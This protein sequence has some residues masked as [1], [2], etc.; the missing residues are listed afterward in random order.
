MNDLPKAAV[1]SCLGGA[2]GDLGV[3]R[4]LGREGVPVTVVAESRQAIALRSR[5][6]RHAVV[7]DTFTT[8]HGRALNSLVAYARQEKHKPVL[9]PTADPDLAFVSNAR[10]ELAKYYHLFVSEKHIID[11]F[12]DKRRFSRLAEK[13]DFPVPR[14][15]I[16]KT[17]GDVSRISEEMEYPA[18][19]KPA[20]SSSWSNR[21]I[22]DIVNDKKAVTVDSPREL[23]DIY[24]RIA[25]YNT[26][27]LIQEYIHGRDDTLYS[28][29]IYFDKKSQPVAYFT[30]RK[31]RTYPAYAGIGC[32]VRSIFVQEIV[33]KGIEMLKRVQYTG[34]ALLQFK[35]DARSNEFR[36][37]EINPR[38]S[39]WNLLAYHCG[40]NLPFLAYADAAG[41]PFNR[42]GT[43]TDNVKYVFFGN[44]I[45]AF[46]EYR[47]HGEWTT[48]SWLKSFRG[49]KVFQLYARDDFGPFFVSC[50]RFV[51]RV[52][53]RIIPR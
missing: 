23:I 9:F 30:G 19:I 41:V 18:I 21:A 13:Y 24:E 22:N 5:Y 38:V 36:L 49:R 3:V 34:L 47:K 26:D 14:T 46:L 37:L 52:L 10:D 11:D 35:R 29:H 50:C 2:Q 44:D 27:M 16:P 33:D 12:M 4:S 53:R 43:Q 42:P 17:I 7:L 25:T 15:F 20:E 48:L 8:D 6:C 28:L 45:R 39:S 51:G 32:L 31:V 40:I 1:L